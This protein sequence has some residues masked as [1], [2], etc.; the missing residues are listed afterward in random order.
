[1]HYANHYIAIVLVILD[2]FPFPLFAFGVGVEGFVDVD[3]NHIFFSFVPLVKI[4][5]IGV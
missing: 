4:I 3:L 2:V 5:A 1:M